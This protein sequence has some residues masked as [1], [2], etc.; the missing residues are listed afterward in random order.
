MDPI[1]I[2]RTL[3]LPISETFI[4][5]QAFALTKY[6]PVYA[7]LRRTVPSLDIE[8]EPIL[9]IDGFDGTC[10][11]EINSYCATG[12]A[13]SF[14]RRAQ[15]VH[16]RLLHVHFAPDG[17]VALPLAEALQVPMVVSLHGYD[18]TIRDEFRMS[19]PSKPFLESRKRMWERTSVFLCGSEFLRQKALEAGYPAE[20]LRVHY[21]GVDLSR[22]RAPT[23]ARVPGLVLFVGRLVEKKGCDTLLR[24]MDLVRQEVPNAFLSIVGDGPLRPALTALASSLS[25]PREFLGAQPSVNVLE[26]MQKATVFCAPSQ[27]AANGDSEGLGIV[28]LEAQACGLPVVTTFH[29]GAPEA[30]RNEETGLLSPEGDHRALAPSLVRYLLNPELAVQHGSAGQA[31]VRSEFDL[32]MRTVRLEQTYAEVLADTQ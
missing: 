24:A 2:F 15:E 32:S 23:V 20:K 8:Q 14:H 11:G 6:R 26:W 17:E 5:S 3:L 18:V 10:D 31:W 9:L 30:V 19:T 25:L 27:T 4:R 29:G 21:I 13:P 16:P 28:L 12:V 22:F 1:L 7:G